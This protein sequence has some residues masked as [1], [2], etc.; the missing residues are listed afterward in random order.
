M[1]SVARAQEPSRA[2]R[3]QGVRA[4]RQ[5]NGLA[6]GIGQ[7]HLAEIQRARILAATFDVVAEHGAANVSVA[8]IVER[9]GVSRRT[10]YEIFSDREDCL[11]AAFEHALELAGRRVLPAYGAPSRWHERIRAGLLALLN[12]FDQ[13]ARRWLVCCWWSRWPVGLRC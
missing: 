6:A 3:S 4:R 10:F 12:F 13:R 8:H 9:S 1:L 2:S 7:A 11:L 5:A